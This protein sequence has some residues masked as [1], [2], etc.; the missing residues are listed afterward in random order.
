MGFW[1]KITDGLAEGVKAGR[2]ANTRA[3]DLLTGR[4]FFQHSS[5]GDDAAAQIEELRAEQR[6]GREEQRE[7]MER[8]ARALE[9]GN[10]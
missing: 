10:R 2:K 9:K 3:D 4:A 7:A 6:Q 8:L 1:K 5:R